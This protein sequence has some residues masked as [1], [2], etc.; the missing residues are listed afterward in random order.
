VLLEDGG[1]IGLGYIVGKGALA[2][3]HARLA[4]G[5]Q[6]LVPGNPDDDEASRFQASSTS[7]CSFPMINNLGDSRIWLKK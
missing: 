6:L 4:R 2:E 3:D 5:G 1:E 7:S